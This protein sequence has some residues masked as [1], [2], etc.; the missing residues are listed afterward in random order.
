MEIFNL[1]AAVVNVVVAWINHTNAKRNR[2]FCERNLQHAR[3]NMELANRL[4]SLQAMMNPNITPLRPI[5]MQPHDA[6]GRP[7]AKD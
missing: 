1:L 4:H 6:Y 3:E 2:E 7:I 5:D